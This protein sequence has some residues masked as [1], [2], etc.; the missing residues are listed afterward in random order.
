MKEHFDAWRESMAINEITGENWGLK[1]VLDF[2]KTAKPSD[3]EHFDYMFGAGVWRI[4]VPIDQK[5]NL[6]GNKYDTYLYNLELSS[7]KDIVLRIREAGQWEILDLFSKKAVRG[8]LSKDRNTGKEVG[9]KQEIKVGKALARALAVWE[10]IL[11]GKGDTVSKDDYPTA[12]MRDYHKDSYDYPHM[13]KDRIWELKRLIKW[14]N[15]YSEKIQPTV[16]VVSRHPIDVLRMS[17]FKGIQSCHSPYGEEED[18]DS[19]FACAVEEAQAAGLVAFLIQAKPFAKIK[20]QLQNDEVFWD[21]D[22]ETGIKG[23][24]PISRARIRLFR[25]DGEG[26]LIAAPEEETYG[27]NVPGF[28][29]NVTDWLHSVQD[30]HIP[31]IKGSNVN[32]YN[33]EG[34]SYI[35]SPEND[36]LRDY[37][38]ETMFV[39]DSKFG[40]IELNE[41]IGKLNEKMSYVNMVYSGWQRGFSAAFQ[42]LV[43]LKEEK[44]F[45]FIAS[46]ARDKLYALQST[47]Q[48]ERIL[49]RGVQDHIL[50]KL[51][52][53]DKRFDRNIV[54]QRVP[55]YEGYLTLKVG[56]QHYPCGFKTFKD[57]ECWIK[58]SVE[59]DKKMKD[60]MENTTAL[61]DLKVFLLKETENVFQEVGSEDEKP[62]G[63]EN[64]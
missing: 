45:R 26:T 36:L 8:V 33:L 56:W 1:K 53:P 43:P 40:T 14:W 6:T 21:G 27:T 49:A 51:P 42:I 62:E 50:S 46:S 39:D 7:V 23:A 34:G 22:R 60:I 18:T 15:T 44:G 38:G 52:A 19:Y 54:I 9:V 57:L 17:D 13:I 58:E 31:D 10:K 37:F 29:N 11:A 3:Y 63:E 28:I 61:R 64:A 16:M 41:K 5:I 4:A 55:N 12:T 47:W 30:D 59:L 35:D 2:M 32:Y 20:D 24:V 48:N 25:H